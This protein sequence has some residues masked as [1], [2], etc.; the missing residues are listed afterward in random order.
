MLSNN[1]KIKINERESLIRS[2][3][4]LKNGNI[5]KKNVEWRNSDFPIL[6]FTK[7][8]SKPIYEMFSFA[9]KQEA[10]VI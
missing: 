4:H 1:E 9:T 8:Q 5:I 3:K 6:N 7:K 2:K 10:P